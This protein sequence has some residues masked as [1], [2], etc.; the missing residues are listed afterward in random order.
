MD[1]YGPAERVGGVFMRGHLMT[2]GEAQERGGVKT[3]RTPPASPPQRE[4]G[5]DSSVNLPPS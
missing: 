5:C 3:P 1:D 4:R 2:S